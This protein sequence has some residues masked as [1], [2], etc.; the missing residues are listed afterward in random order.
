[1]CTSNNMVSPVQVR[2]KKFR[3][4]S[5]GRDPSSHQPVQWEVCMAVCRLPTSR[6][7]L[8]LFLNDSGSPDDREQSL[9]RRWI[10]WRAESLALYP[11]SSLHTN[12]TFGK[13][14]TGNLLPSSQFQEDVYKLFIARRGKKSN[15]FPCWFF[16]HK[17]IYRDLLEELWYLYYYS[18]CVKKHPRGILKLKGMAI[19]HG[20]K[21]AQKNSCYAADLLWNYP[22]RAHPGVLAFFLWCLIRRKNSPDSGD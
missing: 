16:H 3:K 12:S 20:G 2:H 5:S 22:S 10:L 18:F 11:R 14:P 7:G 13:F 17:S 6:W 19:T 8:E 9:W 4:L 21:M 1:M 15:S